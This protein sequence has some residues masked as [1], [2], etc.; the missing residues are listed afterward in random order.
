MNY[1]FSSPAPL[2]LLHI[3]N[4]C[5]KDTFQGLQQ[6][7]GLMHQIITGHCNMQW[8][9]NCLRESWIH[10]LSQTFA[11]RSLIKLGYNVLY[12]GDDRL[13]NTIFCTWQKLPT[14][15]R[16]VYSLRRPGS[17]IHS[18]WYIWYASSLYLHEKGSPNGSQHF[19][20]QHLCT[21]RKR[22]L[23]IDQCAMTSKQTAKDYFFLPRDSFW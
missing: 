21:R 19:Q 8:I 16:A 9:G 1:V 14:A 5:S 7:L 4:F 3:S 13:L 18:R 15:A 6:R 11:R 23:W 22:P 10:L 12:G 2:N 17:P 20:T